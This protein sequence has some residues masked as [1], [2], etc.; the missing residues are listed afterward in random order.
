MERYQFISASD[1]IIQQQSAVKPF[2]EYRDVVVS[3]VPNKMAIAKGKAFD[4][5]LLLILG[6]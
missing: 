2:F 4:L 5:W 1:K 6:G 3:V